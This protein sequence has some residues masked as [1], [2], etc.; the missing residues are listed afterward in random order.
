MN[1]VLNA[2]G[3]P[4]I[5]PGDIVHCRNRS[6]CYRVLVLTASSTALLEPIDESW[7]KKIYCPLD[8]LTLAQ[9]D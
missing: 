3:C 8:L 9:S 5:E 2:K 6:G 1:T 7:V 4:P